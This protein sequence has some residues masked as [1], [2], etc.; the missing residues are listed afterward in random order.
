MT[1][2]PHF[3]P[4][5]MSHENLEAIFVQREKLAQRIVEVVRESATTPSK[6]YRLLIGSRGIGKTHL[7]SLIYHRVKAIEDLRDRLLIAW[8]RE[9]EWGVTSF[10]DLLLRI[11]RA[12]KAELDSTDLNAGRELESRL[13]PIF[14]LPPE[15]AERVAGNL[16]KEYVG[17]R[18]L[19]ILCENLDDM[20]AGLETAGQQR[21]RAYLQENP[22]CT[23]VA[24]AQRLFNGV[25]LQTSPF[26]GFFRIDH[27]QDLTRDEAVQL[28]A[29]IARLKNDRELES[30]IQSPTG[31]SRIRA[32]QH[33]AGGN[34]R[35][36]VIFSQFLTRES[37]DELQTP[38]IQMLNDLT[39][40]Y[41]ARMAWLS[42]QQR[43]I[44]EFLIDRRGAVTVKEIAQ[45]C[46]MTHQTASGQLK[47]LKDMGYVQ[48]ETIGR[49]SYYELREPLM[50][51]CIEMKKSRGEPI[52]LF[53]DFLR[54]WYTQNELTQLLS[55]LQLEKGIDQ[56]YILEALQPNSVEAVDPRVS[57]CLKDYKTYIS[58]DDF[59]N[60]LQAA[61]ELTVLR[62]NVDDWL[63]QAICLLEL[64]RFEEALISVDRAIQLS[65]E[66]ISCWLQ[67]SG[68][69]VELGRFD[70]A[71]ETLEKSIELEKLIGSEARD[72]V[73]K[74]IE[75]AT[76]T[77]R[78]NLL[79][80]LGRWEES[81]VSF[82]QAISLNKKN[83]ICW[84]ARGVTLWVL[85]QKDEALISFTKAVELN[86]ND[87]HS[88][89]NQAAI[90][91]VAE[92]GNLDEA[93]T[94]LN[95]V[96]EIDE[97]YQPAYFLRI[98]VL[99]GLN[100]WG[101][102]IQELDTTLNSF[103][104]FDGWL[105]SHT[106]SIL[107]S[108]FTNTNNSILWNPRISLLIEIYSKHGFIAELGEALVQSIS[109]LNSPM[110]SDTAAQLWLE[111]WQNLTQN[112]PEFQLPLRL[113][114]AAVRYRTTK[115]GRI[116]MEL[117]IEE[118]SLL[119]EV[120]ETKPLAEKKAA[121]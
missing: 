5:L 76:W 121:E 51:F 13:E 95:K 47:G 72:I 82:D 49:E 91:V 25:S 41:Q 106:Q 19:L 50:R 30:F 93:L 15:A 63:S 94:Q 101:E 16:L 46:F 20:F 120:L 35:V 3:T 109:A 66:D 2:I 104:N 9:E 83:A 92:S 24:T 61:E 111:I 102:G 11:F 55:Q 68:I 89:T 38:F 4:S 10:L 59:S 29:K 33:L 58:K 86:P 32:L 43:K 114:D 100:R 45:R 88:R 96:I 64:K 39:P 54:I 7:V 14:E 37:L 115:D 119:A 117:P 22:F 31:R 69:L 107:Q 77:L 53:V 34:H 75:S 99:L 105:T 84:G 81:L 108:L 85:N 36:Y 56:K 103:G 116:L 110:V 65:P 57:A 113:L 118:R 71:L 62:T 40:Y 78:G 90:L 12:I 28:L 87:I 6:H 97:H 18:T 48:S 79:S 8:L 73:I 26:Y 17:H 80:K 74:G 1:A 98:I 67:R 21:L 44:V 42:P 112:R 52:R 23:I 70:E 60:A 27:L